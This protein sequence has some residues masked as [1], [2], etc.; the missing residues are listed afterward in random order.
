VTF[1]FAAGDAF[2]LLHSNRLS[3]DDMGM[4]TPAIVGDRLL[5]RTS[6]RLYCIRGG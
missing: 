6:A 2:K 5:L 4:A 3:A 1:V